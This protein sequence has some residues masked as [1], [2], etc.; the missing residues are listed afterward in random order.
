[1]QRIHLIAAL[2]LLPALAGCAYLSGV[3]AGSI[4]EGIPKLRDRLPR[5]SK[6]YMANAA[7]CAAS[8][9]AGYICG[10]EDLH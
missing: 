6:V 10:P 7:V 5:T 8:A 1:M 2:A 9:V 4:D 3:M